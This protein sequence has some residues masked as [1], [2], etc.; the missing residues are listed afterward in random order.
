VVGDQRRDL[1]RGDQLADVLRFGLGERPGAAV[2]VVERQRA[3]ARAAPQPA[4]V[5]VGIDAAGAERRQR[6]DSARGVL[7][8]EHAAVA[9]LVGERRVGEVGGR[10]GQRRQRLVLRVLDE[11]DGRLARQVEAVDV[12]DRDHDRAHVLDEARDLRVAAVAADQL[13]RPLHRVLARRPLARVMDAHL[14]E[15]RLAVGLPHVA[16]DLDAVHLAALER[17]VVERHRLDQLGRGGR[18]RLHLGLVVVKVPV[19][20]PAGRE[21]GRADALGE[22]AVCGAVAAR[23]D[24]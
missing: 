2:G 4:V 8:V 15:D 13:E 18:Q 20:G 5:A 10:I 23:L 16:R 17:R 19:A 24:R 9:P 12:D 6:A 7:A 22:R 21:P 1:A 3:R 11:V 14:Q